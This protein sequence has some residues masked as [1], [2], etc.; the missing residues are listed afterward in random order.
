MASMLQQIRETRRRADGGANR[1]MA[2]QQLNSS[3]H[4]KLAIARRYDDESFANW[5]LS[6]YAG[7]LR[8]STLA[9]RMIALRERRCVAGALALCSP[10]PA[11]LLD[12]PCGTG[13]LADILMS[14]GRRVYAADLS[15][16][17]MNCARAAYQARDGFRGF[18]RS[19][20]AQLPFADESFDT[21]VCL[22]FVHLLPPDVRRNI[23]KELARITSR[24]LIVSYGV[25]DRFQRVR[26]RLRRLLVAGISTPHP[27]TI[28][29]ARDD[30]A[31][32]GLKLTASFRILPV[33][34]GERVFVLEKVTRQNGGSDVWPRSA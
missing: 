7:S 14:P 3:E 25:A 22:R 11:V 17:M 28:E 26:L 12:M 10:P 5:Y 8:P 13:K 33:L 18:V 9:A 6:A 31:A 4:P 24:R 34:S 2:S 29:T 1:S 32:A 21:I 16:E 30:F 15:M 23:V 27:I 19:D 20:A